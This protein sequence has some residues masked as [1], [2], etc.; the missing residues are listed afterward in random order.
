MA[1][2]SCNL[3][4]LDQPN[5]LNFLRKFSCTPC[6]CSAQTENEEGIHRNLVQNAQWKKRRNGR[7]EEIWALKYE[8]N[9]KTACEVGINSIVLR[10]DTL[11]DPLDIVMKICVP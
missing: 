5:S 1:N 8:F 10:Q 9:D 4:F 6:T 7:K 11:V 3:D 2:Y